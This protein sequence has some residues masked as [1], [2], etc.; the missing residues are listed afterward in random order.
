MI[1]MRIGDGGNGLGLFRLLL[2]VSLEVFKYRIH[3]SDAS[4]G[5]QYVGLLGSSSHT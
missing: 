3:K 5:G 1:G 2:A 4:I